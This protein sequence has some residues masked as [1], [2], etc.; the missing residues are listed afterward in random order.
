V[1]REKTKNCQC[2]LHLFAL[3]KHE[4]ERFS[5]NR[6]FYFMARGY[7]AHA[8]NEEKSMG[9]FKISW[10]LKKPVRCKSTLLEHSS[11]CKNGYIYSK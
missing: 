8:L 11:S 6:Q 1:G 9:K 10:V 4:N 7:F 2:S 5:R 3:I